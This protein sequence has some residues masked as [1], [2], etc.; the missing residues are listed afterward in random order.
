MSLVRLLKTGKSL[1]DLRDSTSRYQMRQKLRLPKFGSQKNPFGPAEPGAASTPI[2]GIAD[3]VPWVMSP[4][5][6]AAARMKHTMRLP[7]LPATA[8]AKKA[9]PAVSAPLPRDGIGSWLGRWLTKLVPSAWRPDGRTIARR[10]ASGRTRTPV[11]GELSLNRI[12]VMRNDLNDADV[13]VVAAKAA[14]KPRSRPVAVA[15]TRRG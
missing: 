4:A 13:E 3:T 8:R 6:K 2:E 11:Q 9:S 12:R 1:T 15:E 5:E 10:P 14:A 7:T